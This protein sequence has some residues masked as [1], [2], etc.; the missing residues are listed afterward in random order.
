MSNNYT[1]V[2]PPVQGDNPQALASGLPPE[3]ADKL[4]YTATMLYWGPIDS[5]NWKEWCKS[6]YFWTMRKL[7]VRLLNISLK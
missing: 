6:K 2:C 7:S 1:K 3:Q 4:W 5:G